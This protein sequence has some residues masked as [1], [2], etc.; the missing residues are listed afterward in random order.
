MTAGL[1]AIPDED[2]KRCFQQWQDHWSKGV[3]AERQYFKGD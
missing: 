3:C 2:L 1:R